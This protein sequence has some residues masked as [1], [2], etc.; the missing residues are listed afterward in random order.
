VVDV[1]KIRDLRLS[2][3]DLSKMV[4]MLRRYIVGAYISNIY[5]HGDAYF[6]KLGGV[7]GRRFLILEPGVRVHFTSMIPEW[8]Y[9]DFVRI[10]RSVLRGRKIM[11]VW[12]YKFDRVMAIEISGGFTLVCEL[13]PRGVLCLVRDG[14]IYASNRYMKMRDR[15]LCPKRQYVFPPNPPKPI[16]EVSYDEFSSLISSRKSV[17]RGLMALGLGPKYSLEVCCRM[18]IDDD[19]DPKG[20]SFEEMERLY[21]GVKNLVKEALSWPG[22][23]VYERNGMPLLFSCV[24]L[25]MCQDYTL[26]KFD[27]FNDAL[28]YYFGGMSIR[29]Y[30][31]SQTASLESRKKEL[32]SIALRQRNF[33]E[34]L[35]RKI[36]R[37]RRLV[38]GLYENHQAITGVL[39]AI[40]RAKDID[41]LEWSE[42][43]RR[44]NTAKDRG[45][46][47][48]RIIDSIHD[49]GTIVFRVQGHE[50]RVHYREDVNKIAGRIFE[51]IKKLEAK[52]E[53]AKRALEETLAK[54]ENLAGEIEKIRRRRIYTIVE[55]R[56]EWY[57]GYRWF[58][59][60]NGILVVAGKDAQTND[61][62]LKKYIGDYDLVLHAEIP[63]GAVV[64]MKDAMNKA[65]N[66]DIM[67]AAVYAASYSRGWEVGYSVMDVF[68]ASPKDISLH[69][70][71][72]MY[73]KKGSF[74]V[75]KKRTIKNVELSISVGAKL[76]FMDSDR[77]WL[78]I[79]SA[80]RNRIRDLADIYVTLHPGKMSRVEVARRIRRMFVEWLSK[81]VG[82]KTAERLVKMERIVELIP[83]SSELAEGTDNID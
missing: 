22:G 43:R 66:E 2:S 25:Y 5:K 21:T 77:V 53:G 34:S 36:L 47:W 40:R 29:K 6:L 38:E 64:L 46:N 52:L 37:L 8:E 70:P 31:L 54:I 74:M 71:S 55:P 28:D 17:Y 30:A 11:D 24:K 1:S 60:S 18:E 59:T 26:R 79:I 82:A 49:D 65:K 45:L 32:E 15:E 68:V 35:E 39:E 58:R 14:V 80:P 48:V 67:E 16:L 50:I 9:S 3:L 76:G 13:I 72:G 63:G 12:Q 61:V 73:M 10:I 51:R 56:K 75:H 83:G 69:P 41:G 4:D 27:L 19:L 20:L 7:Q 81:M 44:L 57:H 62:L 23:F 78:Q 42:I 33:I